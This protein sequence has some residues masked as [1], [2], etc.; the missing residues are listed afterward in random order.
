MR[1]SRCA[2]FEVRTVDGREDINN[3]LLLMC[4]KGGALWTHTAILYLLLLVSIM[5]P[6]DWGNYNI[7]Q[8]ARVRVVLGYD[9]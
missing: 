1:G 7:Q 2:R 4:Y 8:S 5:M 9:Y 6:L 3:I